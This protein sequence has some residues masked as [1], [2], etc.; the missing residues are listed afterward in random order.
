MQR[1]AIDE[2]KNEL[3]AFLRKNLENSSIDLEIFVEENV[4]NTKLFY[5]DD[6]KFKRLN[7]KNPNLNVL[8]QKFNLDF[9]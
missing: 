2:V 5:T 3:L 8:K 9:E 1:E 6:D 4:D 7:E